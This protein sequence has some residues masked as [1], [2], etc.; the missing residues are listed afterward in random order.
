MTVDPNIVGLNTTGFSLLSN[1]DNG[2][3]IDGTAHNNIVGG[4]QDSVIP[5]NTFSGNLGYGVA[6]DGQA[7]DN[8]V[9]NAYVGTNVSGKAAFGNQLGGILIGGTATNNI[10]GDVPS[11]PSRPIAVLVSANDGNGI[12][13]QTG[14]SF[15]QILNNIIGYDSDGN[16]TLPN[17]GQPIVVNGSTNNTISGNQVVACFAAGTRIRT[18]TGDVAVEKL[19]EGDVVLTLDGEAR[20]VQWIGQRRVD[21]LRHPDPATV[22]PIRI[23]A[24]AFAHNRPRRDLYLSPDHAIYAENVLIPVRYLINGATIRQVT[25]EEVTY[26]HIE[27]EKHDV[28]WAEGL[29][30][31]TYLDTGDRA[32]FA[33]GGDVV[34]LHPAWHRPGPEVTLVMDALGYAPL[35]L[36]GPEVRRV[37]AL[38]ATRPERRRR[39]RAA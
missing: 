2:I 35:R 18:P 12:T 16:P 38:L 33:N 36:T 17:I 4:H 13:L 28:V 9:F 3:E 1:G 21:C 39:K 14:T 19:R 37:R 27:L 6:I 30:T 5:R 26:F 7:H 20:P 10:I 15:T 29:P 31:E 25:V 24:H 8:Q 23:A 34:T 32:C 11:T 22:L